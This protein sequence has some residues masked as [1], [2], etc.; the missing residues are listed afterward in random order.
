LINSTQNLRTKFRYAINSPEIKAIWTLVRLSGADYS[1]NTAT[2]IHPRQFN[3]TF[4]LFG[5]FAGKGE[6]MKPVTVYVVCTILAIAGW[7]A[8]ES[9]NGK[10]IDRTFT[11]SVDEG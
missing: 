2:S 1:T 5:Q 7:F 6:K 3:R 9:Q 10:R 8:A 4:T 11:S